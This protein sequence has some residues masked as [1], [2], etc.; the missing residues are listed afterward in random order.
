M[1]RRRPGNVEAIFSR[2]TDESA[3]VDLLAHVVGL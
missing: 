1:L 3:L 2:E